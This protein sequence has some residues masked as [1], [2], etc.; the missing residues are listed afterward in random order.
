MAVLGHHRFEMQGKLTEMQ[1]TAPVYLTVRERWDQASKEEMDNNMVQCRDRD[2]GI[3][4][5]PPTV[6]VN[7]KRR[8]VR[9]KANCLKTSKISK[10]IFDNGSVEVWIVVSDKV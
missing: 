10:Y 9:L 7:W 1:L 4:V 3:I 6:V 2:T 8:C 5:A